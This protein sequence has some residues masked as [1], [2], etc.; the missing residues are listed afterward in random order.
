VQREEMARRRFALPRSTPPANRVSRPFLVNPGFVDFAHILFGKPVSTSPE[1][2]LAR[3]HL[4]DLDLDP[5][6]DFAE[7][8]IEASSLEAPGPLSANLGQNAA[9]Q[10]DLELVED[11]ERVTPA[12]DPLLAPARS[13]LEALAGR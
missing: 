4:G 10:G 1:H 11:I 12:L 6:L 9:E 8:A 5:E 3:R 13:G 2:A 7:H